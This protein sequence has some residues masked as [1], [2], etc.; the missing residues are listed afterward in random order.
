[1]VQGFSLQQR[2]LAMIVSLNQEHGWG[3]DQDAQQQY[4]ATVSGYLSDDCSDAKMRTVITQYHGEHH[5]VEALGNRDHPE[6]DQSWKE[7]TRTV[8]LILQKGRLYW[9]SDP[10]IDPDDLAQIARVE[11]ARSITSFR[12]NSQF[13]TWAHRV[14]INSVQR[15]IRDLHADKRPRGSQSIDESPELELAISMAEDPEVVTRARLLADLVLKLLAAQKDKRLQSIFYLKA[16]EDK[17]IEEIASLVSLHPSRVRTLL[18]EALRLLR[19]HPDMQSWQDSGKSDDER[20]QH[21][22]DD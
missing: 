12:Y 9:S 15:Y 13:G 11:L 5:L 8:V 4:A 16:I 14:V 18:Q 17:R 6:H 7:W 10:A 21:N 1:M 3:L 2:C 22:Q 19:Q 20:Q